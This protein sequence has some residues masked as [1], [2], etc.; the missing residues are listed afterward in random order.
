ML[1][2]NYQISRLLDILNAVK[3]NEGI[4]KAFPSPGARNV[5]ITGPIK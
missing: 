2:Y 5:L 1:F 3:K 4:N